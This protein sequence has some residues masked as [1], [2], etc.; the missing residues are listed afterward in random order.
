MNI[1]RTHIPCHGWEQTENDGE[2]RAFAGPAGTGQNTQLAMAERAAY[3]PQDDVSRVICGADMRTHKGCNLTV[4]LMVCGAFHPL[5]QFRQSLHTGNLLKGCH[6]VLPGMIAG[7]EITQRCEIFR[8]QQQH[9]K[10]TAKLHRAR[11]QAATEH[12]R[13]QRN[14]QRGKK[15]QR[16]RCQKSDFHDR[17]RGAPVGIRQFAYSLKASRS[18]PEQS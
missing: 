4:G 9:K 6:G 8:C 13:N 18:P 5:S 3:I 1:Q 16:G 12:N 10:G 11:Q 17:Q 7:R 14:G 15:F 2:Q